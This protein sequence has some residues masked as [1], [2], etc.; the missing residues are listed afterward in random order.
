MYSGQTQFIC[1]GEASGYTGIRSG[2]ATIMNGPVPRGE[3]RAYSLALTALDRITS[4]ELQEIRNKSEWHRN[5]YE[6]LEIFGRVISR[7]QSRVRRP[8]LHTALQAEFNIDSIIEFSGAWKYW[9]ALSDFVSGAEAVEASGAG[10]PLPLD[11]QLFRGGH[12]L[13][14]TYLDGI[15]RLAIT[16][17]NKVAERLRFNLSST[18]ARSLLDLGAG[19]G[20]YSRTLVNSGLADKATCVD[21]EPAVA[22][23]RAAYDERIT[24]VAEDLFNLT[25]SPGVR[26]GLIYIGNVFH[27]YSLAD[28]SRY[29]GRIAQHLAPGAQIVVQDYL[30]TDDLERSPLY[31]SILGVHFALTSSRGRCFTRDEIS[32]AVASA[33]PTA[34]LQA[35]HHLGTSDLLLYECC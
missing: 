23:A 26:Y 25:L 31:A 4:S 19:P 1:H 13:S 3:G 30:L 29:L 20:V 9:E 17:A 8:S 11:Q 15:E 27:H 35:G 28:N 24:W 10:E 32:S 16:H 2:W 5:L 22:R 18:P 34:R 14:S 12:P 6:A 21:F 7:Y 33:L